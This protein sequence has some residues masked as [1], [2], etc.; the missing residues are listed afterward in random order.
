[1]DHLGGPSVLTRVLPS[2]RGKQEGQSQRCDNS[3]GRTD[4][5]PQAEEC[6]LCLQA[7]KGKDMNVPLEF[8][9]ETPP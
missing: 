3:R 6:G 5:G 8:P 1:M 9:E 4:A 2:E 7:A